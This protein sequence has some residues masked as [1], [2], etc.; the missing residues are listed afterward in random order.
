MKWK[1]S[2]GHR[3]HTRLRLAISRSDWLAC[4]HWA[5][6]S[7]GNGNHSH[8]QEDECKGHTA[9]KNPRLLLPN[10]LKAEQWKKKII[11]AEPKCPSQELAGE[12]AVLFLHSTMPVMALQLQRYG[13]ML[14][15]MRWV[16]R[17]YHQHQEHWTLAW[18]LCYRMHHITLISGSEEAT[19]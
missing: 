18:T 6:F 16:W 12:V 3:L 4:V 13:A 11:L 7:Q 17:G 8:K 5:S 10:P 15:T 14:Q 2:R 19:N 9:G 1:Q